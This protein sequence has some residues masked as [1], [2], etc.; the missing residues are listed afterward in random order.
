[1]SAVEKIYCQGLAG[2]SLTYTLPILAIE[3]I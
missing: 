3:K 1:V 2:L